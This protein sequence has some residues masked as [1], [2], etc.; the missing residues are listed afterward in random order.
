[1]AQRQLPI[2]PTP[3]QQALRDLD[4]ARSLL[5]THVHLASEEWNPKK[6]LRQSVQKHPWAWMAAAGVGGLLL[7]R[8]IMPARRGKIDRDIS[9]ASGTKIGFMA[10]L[11]QP[12][13]AM[14]RQ[15][16]FKH[17]S[18]FLQSYLTNHFSKHAGS[19]QVTDEPSAHV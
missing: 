9:V 18:Q 4:E 13:L 16:A 6:L 8:A 2:K 7:L 14:A 15:A 19:P 12:V 10:L 5:G 17:G 3:K 11:M 1:M